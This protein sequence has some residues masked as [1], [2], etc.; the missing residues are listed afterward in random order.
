MYPIPSPT[1][2]VSQASMGQLASMMF[3]I[4]QVVLDHASMQLFRQRISRPTEKERQRAIELYYAAPPP[5][6]AQFLQVSPVHGALCGSDR[7]RMGCCAARTPSASVSDPCRPACCA[8][9][10]FGV[11]GCGCTRS[12]AVRSM[13]ALR[14]GWRSTTATSS[15]RAAE[16]R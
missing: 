4:M 8:V 10:R 2:S 5:N 15:A 16:R 11:L 3:S 14:G 12:T 13:S 6:Y 1:T 9:L 7:S